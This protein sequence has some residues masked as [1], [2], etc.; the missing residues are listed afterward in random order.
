MTKNSLFASKTKHE[1]FMSW[2]TS[3]GKP[4][5]DNFTIRFLLI[6]GQNHK[7]LDGGKM[8]KGLKEFVTATTL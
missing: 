7:T 5:G 8:Q 2:S 4:D 3:R 6:L 1:Q